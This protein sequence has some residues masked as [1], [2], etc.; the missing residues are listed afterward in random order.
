MLHDPCDAAQ[1]PLGQRGRLRFRDVA[2]RDDVRREPQQVEEAR[3]AGAAQP[4]GRPELRDGAV[5]A[6]VE[7]VSQQPGPR[8]EMLEACQAR[9]PPRVLDRE[10]LARE[11]PVLPDLVNGGELR[12]LLELDLLRDGR[13]ARHLV[14]VGLNLRAE[15]RERELLVD[16]G[17]GAALHRREG[18]RRAARG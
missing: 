9:D 15:L 17:A 18:D 10:E 8:E 14:E 2:P 6:R 7:A 1:L 5:G 3:G 11:L 4:L 12:E 16:A 13:G